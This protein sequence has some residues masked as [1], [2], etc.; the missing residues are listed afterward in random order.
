MR[1]A[2]DTG[3]TVSVVNRSAMEALGYDPAAAGT[4]VRLTTGSGVEFVPVITLERI[5]AL[6]HQRRGF[7]VVCHT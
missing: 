7:P 2:L 5:R 4:H 3:A 6:R 1:L